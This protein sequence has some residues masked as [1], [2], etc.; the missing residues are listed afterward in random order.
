[1][2]ELLQLI[3]SYMKKIVYSLIL[4]SIIISI[5]CNR[6]KKQGLVFYEGGNAQ[7]KAGNLI[8]AIVYFNKAIALDPTKA[9]FYMARANAKLSIVDYTGAIA[10]YTKVIHLDPKRAEAYLSRGVVKVYMKDFSTEAVADLTQAIQLNPALTNAYYNRGVIK[11]VQ[12]DLDAACADW[13]KA[14]EMGSPLAVSK[15]KT[16]CK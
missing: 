6:H 5:S 10:D 16:Y 12:H 2:V 1:M 8:N 14:A 9:D 3:F 13:K 7:V 11:Y 4:F 15:V